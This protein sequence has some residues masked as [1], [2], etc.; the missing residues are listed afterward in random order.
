MQRMQEVHFAVSVSEGSWAGIVPMGHFI[1]QRT[2]WTQDLPAW[3]FMG[4]VRASGGIP[5][6]DGVFGHGSHRRRIGRN[7]GFQGI[8]RFRECII[9]GS[10]SI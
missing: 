3:G 4:R 8:L 9:I 1:A 5:A 7:G 2:Q 6:H 10:V